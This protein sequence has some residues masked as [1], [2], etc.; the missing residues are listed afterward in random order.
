[1]TSQLPIISKQ[2]IGTLFLSCA[3]HKLVLNYFHCLRKFI[4]HK[5][6][7]LISICLWRD[8]LNPEWKF[9]RGCARSISR[10]FSRKITQKAWNQQKLAN[11]THIFRSE[12]PLRNF[13]LPFKKSRF[14][15]KISLR[16]D[17]INLPIYVLSAKGTRTT[18]PVT[19]LIRS[20]STNFRTISSNLF[21]RSF[22]DILSCFFRLRIYR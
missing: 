9:P 4:L 22:V 18:V 20:K 5:T 19:P 1:M 10:T 8:A 16:G 6:L 13:G 12:I 2:A 15:E 11:G 17:R 21:L 3:L 14:P 7:V